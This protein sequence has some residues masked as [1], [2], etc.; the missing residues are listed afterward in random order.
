MTVLRM[1]ERDLPGDI[2]AP[3]PFT[4]ERETW[5]YPCAE[6]DSLF[7]VDHPISGQR[8]LVVTQADGFCK[9]LIPYDE[10]DGHSA[11]EAVHALRALNCFD[12][13]IEC[14]ERLQGFALEYG[15]TS[16]V[17]AGEGMFAEIRQ[18]LAKAKGE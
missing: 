6:V 5:T 18:V 13:L 15:S 10:E 4:I 16:A 8:Q 1:V 11:A 12:E 7:G 14:V 9:V 2:M 17:K 3:G